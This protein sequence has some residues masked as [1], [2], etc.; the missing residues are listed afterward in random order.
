MGGSLP[1][2]STAQEAW[3]RVEG[4]STTLDP[5]RDSRPGSTQLPGC[6]TLD[7]PLSLSV[8]YMSDAPKSPCHVGTS[9]R[10]DEREGAGT[11]Q[12][13]GRE[14]PRSGCCA[15]GCCGFGGGPVAAPGARWAR[16]AERLTG[17]GPAEGRRLKRVLPAACASLLLG[18]PDVHGYPRASPTPQPCPL[19]KSSVHRWLVTGR[20]TNRDSRRHDTPM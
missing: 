12:R 13:P 9:R 3:F 19:R 14:R 11:R 8:P 6:A 16:S 7:G 17:R 20:I 4:K 10:C 5:N 2:P 18:V 15:C 1:L